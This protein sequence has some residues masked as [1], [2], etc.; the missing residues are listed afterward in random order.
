MKKHPV[1]LLHSITTGK[2][3]NNSSGARATG[4]ELLCLLQPP[5]KCNNVALQ[6]L[7][8]A[9]PRSSRAGPGD[10]TAWMNVWHLPFLGTSQSWEHGDRWKHRDVKRAVLLWFL[11]A[12][13]P[14]RK[15]TRI[16]RGWRREVGRTFTEKEIEEERPSAFNLLHILPFWPLHSLPTGLCKILSNS[17]PLLQHLK[18]LH[19]QKHAQQVVGTKN[20]QK[21]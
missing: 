10:K 11:W 13:L 3:I 15:E 8:S 16:T 21:I 6:S 19:G 17:Y 18:Q 4:W 14:F 9:L 5:F 20:N 1:P 7:I 2:P 12:A